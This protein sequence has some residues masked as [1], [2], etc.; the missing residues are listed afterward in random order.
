MDNAFYLIVGAALVAGGV[1][2]LRGSKVVLVR[3]AAAAGIAAGGIMF[4]VGLVNA[5]S[6]T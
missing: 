4:F 3:S 5:L 2:A 1:V 6:G